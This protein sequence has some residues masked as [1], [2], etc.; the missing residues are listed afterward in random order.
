MKYKTASNI[1]YYFLGLFLLCGIFP[2]AW[3][4][5][6]ISGYTPEECMKCHRLKS[7][8]SSLL[9]SLEKYESS[10]HGR[11]LTCLGCHPDI[12][13]DE[14][15][16]GDG[17]KPVDC[18]RCHGMKTGRTGIFSRFT[19]FRISSH[20][21]ADFAG[22]YKIDNCLGCHQGAGAHGEA[23]PIN[24]QDCFKCHDSGLKNALWGKIHP[25]QRN[26]ALPVVI[27]HICFAL[28]FLF[29]FMRQ[30]NPVFD[31]VLGKIN[32]KGKR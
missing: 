1:G 32:N 7:G 15:M 5:E 24:D 16:E 25:D 3:A 12:T 28:F 29:A 4:S 30:M 6:D 18:S 31:R 9:V 27:L 10:A 2:P 11:T 23:G 19:T 22:N 13:G 14:H 17:I 21:K 8:E 20:G 26:K